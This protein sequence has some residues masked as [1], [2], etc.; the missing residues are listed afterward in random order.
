M[1]SNEAKTNCSPAPFLHLIT[2]ACSDCHSQIF[3]YE[4]LSPL[5]QLIEQGTLSEGNDRIMLNM[6]S[7]FYLLKLYGSMI[8]IHHYVYQGVVSKLRR[9]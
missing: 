2:S 7:G 6:K 8:R 5:G 9:E 3:R 1:N 4:I